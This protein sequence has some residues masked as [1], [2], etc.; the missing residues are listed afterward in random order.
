MRSTIG[1]HLHVPLVAYIGTSGA[2][3]ANR[4]LS[5]LPFFTNDR[6]VEL[7]RGNNTIHILYPSECFSRPNKRARNCRT[8]F[9]HVMF[10]DQLSNIIVG[11]RWGVR[12]RSFHIGGAFGLAPSTSLNQ[13]N[14]AV[15]F[16]CDQLLHCFCP[17]PSHAP[18]PLLSGKWKSTAFLYFKILLLHDI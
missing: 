9:L 7:S 14:Q 12:A 17:C 4:D 3:P 11:E 1:E 2:W 5:V 16:W 18:T 10:N 6:S 15:P 13:Y 8:H